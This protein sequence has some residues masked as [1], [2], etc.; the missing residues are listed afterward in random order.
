MLKSSIN[1]YEFNEQVNS[2]T[3]PH[4]YIERSL[5]TSTVPGSEE[6]VVCETNNPPALPEFVLVVI[7]RKEK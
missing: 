3:A 2:T 7:S 1:K 5:R 6:K 4:T